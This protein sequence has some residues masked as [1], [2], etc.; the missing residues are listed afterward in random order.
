[1]NKARILELADKIDG[2]PSL[3]WD[4]SDRLY[5][6]RHAFNMGSAKHDCGTPA[7]IAGWAAHMYCGGETRGE[8][9]DDLDD[10][11]EALGL[12]HDQ[13]TELFVPVVKSVAHYR[14]KNPG[15]PGFVTSE[16]AAAVL[17]NLA[18]TGEIDWTVGAGS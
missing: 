7:C 12:T 10:A 17:R 15:D 11:E 4:D 13:G 6:G 14:A 8:W 18:E 5:R 16:H 3:S 9:D 1:M 2:L